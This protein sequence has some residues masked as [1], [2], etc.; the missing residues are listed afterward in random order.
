MC[1]NVILISL[2]LLD[3]LIK[4]KKVNFSCPNFENIRNGK[5]FKDFNFFCKNKLKSTVKNYI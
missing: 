2:Y 4:K 5:L 3:A 1:K